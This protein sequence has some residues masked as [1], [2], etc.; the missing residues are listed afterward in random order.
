M[1]LTIVTIPEVNIRIK[2]CGQLS[3]VSIWEETPK[4]NPDGIFHSQNRTK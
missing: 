3:E 2:F 1:Q 4:V